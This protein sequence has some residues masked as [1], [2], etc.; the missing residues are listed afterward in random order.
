MVYGL[1]MDLTSVLKPIM[2]PI[3]RSVA[4]SVLHP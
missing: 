2:V 1:A 4:T 3:F